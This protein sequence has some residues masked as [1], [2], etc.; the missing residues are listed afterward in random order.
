[1]IPPTIFSIDSEM[2]YLDN[3]EQRM[4]IVFVVFSFIFCF[5]QEYSE[6]KQKNDATT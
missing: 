2:L 3:I 1:M 6:K 5:W 4:A